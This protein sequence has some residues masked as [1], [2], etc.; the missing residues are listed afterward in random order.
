[1]KYPVQYFCGQRLLMHTREYIQQSL[2]LVSDEFPIVGAVGV[3]G[4]KLDFNC[5]LRLQIPKGNWH[6]RIS[7][8]ASGLLFIDRD[9]SAVT[10]I[11]LEKFY[12]EWDIT[13]WF[14]GRQVLHHRFDPRGRKVHF[15]LSKTLGDNIILLPY[16]E[17]FRRTFECD[18]TCRMPEPYHDI[19][20]KYFPRFRLTNDFR[21]SPPPPLPPPAD[22]YACYYMSAWMARPTAATG[23]MR[24]MPLTL[25][26]RMVLDTPKLK[27]P[28]KVIY[29]PTKPREI[30]EPYVCIGVQ[31][32]SNPKCWLN[33]NGW[34]QVVDYLKSIGYRVLC[35]DRDRSHTDHDM[36]VEMP[37]GAEDFS[38]DYTLIDRVN[39]LAYADFF[40][41]LS[42]GLSWLAWS[43][44][45]PVVLISGFSE[46][47]CEFDTPYR[48][49]NP[50]VCHGC[51]NHRPNE[52]HMILD[53]ISRDDLGERKYECSKKISARMVIEAIDRLI[54][55]KQLNP[56]RGRS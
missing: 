8:G 42:S 30:A 27:T 56:T 14:K 51:F 55:D 41:G 12:V 4:V 26:G 16:I 38:G 54:A 21:K 52:T 6:V 17:E 15:N 33:P 37:E 34:D 20:R 48:V 53:C 31:A 47:W 36:T 50:L 22:T 11:S 24:S 2:A 40:I 45:I 25:I 3:K 19:V 29:R 28:S 32:S 23:D 5:G 35:I 44:D 7:D 49:N 39:Q 46:P 9:A 13:L 18:V 10:L 43:V 1:M